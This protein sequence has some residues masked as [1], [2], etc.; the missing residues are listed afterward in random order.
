MAKQFDDVSRT[1]QNH[2]RVLMDFEYLNEGCTPVNDQSSSKESQTLVPFPISL[3]SIAV[4]APQ[5]VTPPITTVL[6]PY[7]FDQGVIRRC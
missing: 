3:R 6:L 2:A 7:I 1:N 4:S 5:F